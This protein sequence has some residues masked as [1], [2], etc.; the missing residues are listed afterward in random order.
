MKN[1]T[2]VNPCIT[3]SIFRCACD[4]F[5][6]QNTFVQNRKET[7]K[8]AEGKEVD[9]ILSRPVT[10][11]KSRLQT[12]KQRGARTHTH[13]HS[14]VQTWPETIH[15]HTQAVSN[16]RLACTFILEWNSLDFLR[17][18]TWIW[19][20]TWSHTHTHVTHTH[21]KGAFCNHGDEKPPAISHKNM[22]FN[23]KQNI[24]HNL[25]HYLFSNKK[26]RK[27]SAI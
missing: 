19:L 22:H 15:I 13:T 20:E 3:H 16:T 27:W 7:D 23:Y 10:S 14:S 2:Q 5:P 25:S 21:T 26:E 17:A 6:K 12:A 1:F 24:Q 18:R 4:A 8:H 9:C 11:S